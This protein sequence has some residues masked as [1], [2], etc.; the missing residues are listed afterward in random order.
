MG[1]EQC[2]H[3]DVWRQRSERRAFDGEQ[4]DDAD[5]AICADA[6]ILHDFQYPLARQP[7]AKAIA[8]V[9]EAVFMEG[10]RQINAG[11]DGQQHG[12]RRRQEPAGQQIHCAGNGR[13]HHADQ[14]EVARGV[15]QPGRFET[16]PARNRQARKELQRNEEEA[17]LM[18]CG[19]NGIG[20][21]L[22]LA[23]TFR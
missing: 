6:R 18:D 7:T 10:A 20:H 2:R 19:G 4:A 13:H 9:G 17:A 16:H 22:S 1:D 23:W 11:G 12:Q 8:H 21:G 14:R 3:D 15:L 5:G